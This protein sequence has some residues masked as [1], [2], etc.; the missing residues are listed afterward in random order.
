LE[1]I[2][3]T[4]TKDRRTYD[5]QCGLAYAL[6]VVGE[7]W[8]LLIIRE[9]LLRPR[10]YGELLDALPGI[11][12]NLLADRLA[13]LTDAGLIRPLDPARRTAGY[14]CTELGYR[15]HEPILGLARFG[16]VVMAESPEQ[17]STIRA[18]WSVLAIEAMVD[19]SR[20][21]GVDEVYEFTVD[22][23]VFHVRVEKGRVH[24]VPGAAADA[25]LRIGTDAATFFK[26]GARR[27]DPIEAILDGAV[28]VE[29]PSAAV[30]R[31]LR[32]LGL[33]ANMGNGN[34]SGGGRSGAPVAAR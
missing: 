32:L 24:T 1:G 33:G 13:F 22:T 23:E 14:E 8:T 16:L 29:G 4:T 12:T 10:R 26:L 27:L 17:A 18:S 25:T 28:T 31:C 15:L 9:L 20:A 5:Q 2:V 34:G 11:G 7:R 21:S 30:P 6:D 3:K 19:E